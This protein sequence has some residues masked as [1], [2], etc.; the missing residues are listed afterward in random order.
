MSDLEQRLRSA[1]VRRSDDFEPSPDLPDRIGDRVQ[2]RRRARRVTSGTLVA[3]AAALVVVVSLVA[4]GAYHEDSMWATNPAH[5][6]KTVP[7]DG[8]APDTT[9]P[10]ASSV[11]ETTPGAV[12]SPTSVPSVTFPRSTGA[13]TATSPTAA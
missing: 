11:P 12:A 3:A 4:T 10:T 6:T 9:G 7:D 5:H 1:V 13:T 2:Q 8:T